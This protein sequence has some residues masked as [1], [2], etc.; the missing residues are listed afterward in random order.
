MSYFPNVK[1]PIKNSANNAYQ[2]DVVGNKTDDGGG[3]SLVSRSFINDKHEH[4]PAKVYPSQAVGIDVTKSDNPWE[5][6]DFA[7]VVPA[8]T[9]TD[10]FDIHSINFDNVPT[11]GVYEIVL[12]AGADSA[13]VEI[14]RT[15][16]T[17]Q[18]ASSVEFESMFMSPICP[19]NTQIK[20]KLCGSNGAA[21]TVVISIRY[22]T[23]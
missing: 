10:Y 6:G 2:S 13:E 14:G 17:R 16:F 1:V 5:L 19:P 12:Y 22:H 4:S 7:V 3:D 21:T 15:R 11:N 8:N 20:A 23:Y 9:I 18:L